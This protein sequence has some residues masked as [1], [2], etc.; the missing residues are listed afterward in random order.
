MALWRVNGKL[1]GKC[2]RELFGGEKHS[3]G[4]NLEVVKAVWDCYADINLKIDAKVAYALSDAP[5]FKDLDSVDVLDFF[6]SYPLCPPRG[7]WVQ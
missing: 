5:L 2:L 3:L 6:F 7:T 1:D 4:A